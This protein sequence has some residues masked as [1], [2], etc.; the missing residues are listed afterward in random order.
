LNDVD[1]ASRPAFITFEVAV[2]AVRPTETLENLPVS[3]MQ[4]QPCDSIAVVNSRSDM[5]TESQTESTVV[6]LNDMPS[7]VKQRLRRKIAGELTEFPIS[8]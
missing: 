1:N 6:S 4:C 5:S 8:R 2:S 7:G 3:H